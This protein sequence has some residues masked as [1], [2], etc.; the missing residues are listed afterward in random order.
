MPYS[1]FSQGAGE[2]RFQQVPSG[3]GQC[4]IAR[5]CLSAAEKQHALGD[6]ADGSASD[7]GNAPDYADEES[8][9]W[10][11]QTGSP[12]QEVRSEKEQA[13]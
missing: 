3:V 7:D 2:A 4:E 13:E 9:T 10:V 6:N 11:D 5:L 8:Q 1:P 12:K